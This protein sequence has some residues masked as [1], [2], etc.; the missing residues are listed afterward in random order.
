[1]EKHVPE[2]AK[3]TPYDKNVSK[4]ALREAENYHKQQLKIEEKTAREYQKIQDQK[5]KQ[6][7]KNQSA[8]DKVNAKQSFAQYQQRAIDKNAHNKSLVD[9]GKQMLE[10]YKLK[11]DQQRKIDIQAEKEHIK[12]IEKQSKKAASAESKISTSQRI[13]Q[14]KQR[15]I[16]KNAH[17]Q[18]L[19]GSVKQFYENKK[20]EIAEKKRIQE[21]NKETES[22]IKNKFETGKYSA[23]KTRMQSQLNSYR[24]QPSNSYLDNAKS[25]YDS[26]NKSLDRINSHFSGKY[27]LTTDTLKSEFENLEKASTS[28]K[29]SISEVGDTMSK[30]LDNSVFQQRAN[31]VEKYFDRNIDAAK[32]YKKEF[33]DLQ[34]LYLSASTKEDKDMLDDEFERL[35]YKTSEKQKALNKQ[36]QE[37]KRAEKQRLDEENRIAKENEKRKTDVKYDIE[38]GKYSALK[39]RMQSQLDKYSG[40]DNLSLNKASEAMKDFDDEFAK[41]KSHIDGTKTLS[42]DEFNSAFDKMSKSIDTFK[43]KMSE[44]GS[45]M[46]KSLDPGIAERGANKVAAYYEENSKAVK[47]Y[48]ES[49][50]LLEAQFRNATTLEDKANAEKAFS[51]LKSRISAEGLTGKSAKDEAKRAFSQIAEFTGFY[52]VAQNLM[53]EFPAKVIQ[54][55]RDYDDAMVS[56]RMATGVSNDQAR[57][58][59]STYSDI[60]KQLK[61]TGTDVAQSSVEWMKQGKSIEEANKLTQDSIILSKIGGLSSTDATKTITAAM[62]SYKM[63]ESEV[64]SFV[65]SISAIDMASATDVGGLAQAFNE[66]AANAKEGGVESSKLLAYAAAI[67]ET[68]QEG[69]ASVGT[70]LNAIFS[71]MGNIKLSRLKDFETGEDLS[72]VETVLKG[73]GISLRDSTDEFRE[74]DD[75]LAE[76]ASN[77]TKYSGVQK[78]A[79]AQAFAG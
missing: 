78:R 49:L 71:R 35:K 51:S 25:S 1:M 56:L 9:S 21:Q 26:Y 23:L 45:T 64:M 73:V 70:S 60:G 50:K 79:I 10:N 77:W 32:E 34:D 5:I 12:Q 38:T 63:S 61:A 74:F 44:V 4:N 22:H 52:G 53:Q 19:V 17:T 18:E 72:N 76:T 24:N 66:V 48:G 6:S 13:A 3:P 27:T 39:T 54:S 30:T 20:A 37:E 65:D 15:A 31:E 75:V 33:K 46:S 40:Q 14:Y 57:D 11:R 55:V 59:M 8:I 29:N 68:T 41:L 43:N 62:K 7:R 2:I 16:D 58:L 28:F 36:I 47:K 42:D 67:G 69:M